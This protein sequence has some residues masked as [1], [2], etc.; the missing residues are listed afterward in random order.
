MNIETY[1]EK[2]RDGSLS[3]DDAMALSRWDFDELCQSANDLRKEIWGNSFDFCAIINGKSGRCSENCKYC[4]QSGHY[5][6]SVEIYPLLDSE[7]ICED[8]LCHDK[9]G[10]GR[11]SVVTSGKA[12]TEE[13]VKDLCQ[14]YR[15]IQ[16]CSTISLCASHGLLTKEQFA[17]LKGKFF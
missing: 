16:K 2:S 17:Q 7:T 11:Y 8:A 13:E 15:T 5:P 3:K 9:Q 14:S 12:L 4:A 10:V 6:T 1:M